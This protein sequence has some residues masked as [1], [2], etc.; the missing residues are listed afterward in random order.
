MHWVRGLPVSL[1][2]A[3]FF[4]LDSEE[5]SPIWLHLAMLPVE[6]GSVVFPH[7]ILSPRRVRPSHCTDLT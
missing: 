4:N 2:S 1:L 3:T 5:S 6:L 7:W